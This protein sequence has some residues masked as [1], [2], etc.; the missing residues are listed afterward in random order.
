MSQLA[1]VQNRGGRQ[2]PWL[3]VVAVAVASGLWLS[4]GPV[5]DALIFDRSAIAGGEWWRLLSGHWVHSDGR[6]ALWDIAALALVGGLVETGGRRRLALAAVVGSLWVSAALWW[7]LPE[8]ERYCGLSGMLNTLFVI[9][10]ADLWQRGHQPVVVAAA[11]LL[12]AK[13]LAELAAGQSVLIDPLWPGVPLAHLAGLLGG[14][15]FLAG[16]RAYHQ[17]RNHRFS[18]DDSPVDSTKP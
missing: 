8:L 15:A 13:L 6:H 4:L 1:I 7:Q 12:S 10:L 11:L 3:T 5:P 2:P 17:L 18:R 14:L 16:D 9:A